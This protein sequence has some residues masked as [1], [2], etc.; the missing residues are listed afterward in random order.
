MPKKPWIINLV[1]SFLFLLPVAVAVF[2]YFYTGD[3]WSRVISALSYEVFLLGLACY[4]AAFGVWRVRPWGY[5]LFFFF[6][7]MVLFLDLSQIVKG[8]NSFTWWIALDLALIAAG[9]LL[10]RS[11][12]IYEPYFKP[13]VRWWERADR[14]R[15]E[16]PGSFS[17]SERSYDAQILDISETGLF[18]DLSEGFQVGESLK[19]KILFNDFL[20]E[21]KAS[22]V[23]VSQAP[24]GM[25]FKFVDLDSQN[26]KAVRNIIAELQKIGEG[27]GIDPKIKSVAPANR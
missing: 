7:A 16:V 2:I 4:L 18:A 24:R 17:S 13:Q 20:F 10:F 15:I 26:K 1:A 12:K 19:I 5:Y 22:T 3:N 21:S 27:K 23:R 14:F 9:V 8:R 25:G 11:R 6:V